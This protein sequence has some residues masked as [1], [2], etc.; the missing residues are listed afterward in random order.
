MA[1]RARIIRGEVGKGRP[2]LVIHI[3]WEI[4][5][6]VAIASGDGR[7]A[8]L[9]DKLLAVLIHVLEHERDIGR[10]SIP[11]ANKDGV[12]LAIEIA[13][14]WVLEV[15]E[16]VIKTM[17]NDRAIFDGTGFVAIRWSATH[18]LGEA[19]GEETDTCH[20]R[21]DDAEETHF[22]T[23]CPLL[24]G[25][26][27]PW[28]TLMVKRIEISTIKPSNSPQDRKRMGGTKQVKM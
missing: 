23:P 7:I 22:L 10:S 1:I 13:H 3:A 6:K 9:R 4:P 21:K 20:K 2:V 8:S 19:E 24:F 5:I 16:I 14:L 18:G 17:D 27:Y 26:S 28:M 12:R 25:G 11:S 15:G